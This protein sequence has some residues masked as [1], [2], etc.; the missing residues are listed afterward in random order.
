MAVGVQYDVLELPLSFDTHLPPII[1][2]LTSELIASQRHLHLSLRY[3]GPFTL[4][5]HLLSL[6]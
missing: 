6:T 5:P 4:Q 1:D 3:I 2:L